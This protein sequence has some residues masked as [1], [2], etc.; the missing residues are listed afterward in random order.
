[1][2]E[3]YK[4]EGEEGALMD[5]DDLEAESRSLKERQDAI[6]RQV[7]ALKDDP[8]NAELLRQ[9]WQDVKQHAERLSQFVNA[10]IKLR[11]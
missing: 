2:L 9:Y 7:A 11:Q 3:A 1:M 10:L 8:R 5:W 4:Q 6:E